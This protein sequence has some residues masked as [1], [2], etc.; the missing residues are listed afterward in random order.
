MY[1]VTYLSAS[2]PLPPLTY[3]LI[4][5][6]VRIKAVEMIEGATLSLKVLTPIRLL[7]YREKQN[8]FGREMLDL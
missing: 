1:I 2:D 3:S 6:T 4:S 8:Q 5:M 7:L